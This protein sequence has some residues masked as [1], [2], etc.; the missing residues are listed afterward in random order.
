VDGLGRPVPGVNVRVSWTRL[1]GPA[2]GHEVTLLS[3]RSD[4]KGNVRGTY[5]EKLM[6]GEGFQSVSMSKEGYPR[7]QGPTGRFL[8]EYRFDRVFHRADVDRVAKLDTKSRLSELREILAGSLQDADVESEIFVRDRAF[9]AT[10]RELADDPHMGLDVLCLLASI[11]VPEDLAWV[12]PRLPS[13]KKDETWENRWACVIVGGLLD[14][15]TDAE[16]AFLKRCA[17]GEFEYEAVQGEAIT[18]LRLIASPRSREVLEALHVDDDDVTATIAQAI[19]HIKT[20]P[21]P[22][23]DRNVDKLRRRLAAELRCGKWRGNSEPLFNK[24]R[25]KA[26]IGLSFAAGTESISFTAVFHKVGEVW[27]LRGFRLW[28]LGT[29]AV[30]VDDA[31]VRKK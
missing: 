17:T 18:I 30:T 22:F 2:K 11:G 15:T 19:E 24:E 3:L 26:R 31:E 28:S 29:L 27:K 9:R 7:D 16:W 8:P 5:D 1:D 25:D 14:P 6:T 23:A 21:P 12:V 13:P 20:N 10:L 4:D